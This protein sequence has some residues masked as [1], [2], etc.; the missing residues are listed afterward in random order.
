MAHPNIL[1]GFSDAARTAHN[2]Y[3]DGAVRCCGSG[4][5]RFMAPE[6]AIGGLPGIARWSSEPGCCGW[7][8]RHSGV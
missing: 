4:A 7:R 3:Y 5:N 8:R 6:R 1:T 2:S